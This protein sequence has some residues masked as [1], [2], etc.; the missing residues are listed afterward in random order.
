MLARA[1]KTWPVSRQLAVRSQTHEA[2]P[3]VPLSDLPHHLVRAAV[4]QSLAGP[5]LSLMTFLP[6]SDAGRHLVYA[7][8]GTRLLLRFTHL[9]DDVHNVQMSWDRWLKNVSASAQ[10]SLGGRD[11]DPRRPGSLRLFPLEHSCPALCVSRIWRI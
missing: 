8:I 10:F 3:S 7:T 11:A 2:C 1:A 6:L 4:L 5:A 9:L